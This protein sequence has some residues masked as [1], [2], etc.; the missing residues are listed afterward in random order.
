MNKDCLARVMVLNWKRVCILSP[1]IKKWLS[2]D[3]CGETT[4]TGLPTEV[5]DASLEVIQDRLDRDL[6]IVI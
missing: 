4:G 3:E 5:V 6:S 2:N 1:G